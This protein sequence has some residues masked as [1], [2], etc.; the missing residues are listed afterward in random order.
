M[1]FNID[2]HQVFQQNYAAIIK[3]RVVSQS[4]EGDINAAK[5]YQRQTN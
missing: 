1:V 3:K 4:I 2:F 5:I